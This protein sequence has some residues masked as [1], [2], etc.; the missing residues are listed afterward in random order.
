MRVFWD[1]NNGSFDFLT[2]CMLFSNRLNS[3]CCQL[4]QFHWKMRKTLLIRLDFFGHY[5]WVEHH[6]I[7]HQTNRMCSSIGDQTRTL[8][9]ASNERKSKIES[10]RAFTRFT[11][12]L[13]KQTWTS[14]FE[15]W[16]ISNVYR[17]A[18]KNGS[19]SFHIKLDHSENLFNIRVSCYSYCCC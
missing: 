1:E 12:L 9:F 10:N 7:E 3:Q 16:T 8:F 14:F 4:W 19:I 2:I 6:F 13:I 15:N 11:K 18:K 17:I 5:L